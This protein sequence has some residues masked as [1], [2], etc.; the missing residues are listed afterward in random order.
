MGRLDDAVTCYNSALESDPCNAEIWY[1]KGITL[2]KQGRD[3][4]ASACM[5]NALSLALGKR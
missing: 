5:Q 3:S 2:K 4:E 1:N